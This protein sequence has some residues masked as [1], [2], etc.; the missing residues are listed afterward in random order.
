MQ[1]VF[2]SGTLWTIPK[3][4]LAG[5][6]VAVP[7][8]VKFGA[9]QD[10]SI[11]ISFDKKEL[12]GQ[13]AFPIEVARGKGKIDCKS[14]CAAL[15]ANVFNMAFGETMNTGEIR[16]VYNEAGTIPASSTY[17]ITVAQAGT[18][19]T[20]LGVVY[21][22]NGQSLTRVASI[23]TTGGIAAFSIYAGGSGYHLGDVLT[24]ANGA[25][26]ELLVTAID[27]N[28]AVTGAEIDMAGT[29]CSIASQVETTVSPSGGTGCK[30]NILGIGAYGQYSVTNGVYTFNSADEGVAVLISYTYTYAAAPGENF[31]INNQLMGLAPYFA[32]VF[33]VS[34]LGKTFNLQLFQ[35]VSTKLT[36]ATKLD[37]FMIPEFD[38]SSMAN[39]ANQIGSMSIA[40]I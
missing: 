7:T 33:N 39:S 16:G 34:H 36:M 1:T 23:V 8:P 15:D 5:A 10:V 13:Y 4:T 19:V 29:G 40:N 37:D 26:A 31:I 28:G 20:D 25:N 24:V 22:S 6:S 9:I 17:T 18:F 14:K 30:I 11:D 2:G 35:N 27:A 12:Y 32:I 3:Y 38:F 21:A